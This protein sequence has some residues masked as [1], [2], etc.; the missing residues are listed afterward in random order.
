MKDNSLEV[1]R[2]NQ[3]NF[4]NNVILCNLLDRE[5]FTEIYKESNILKKFQNK[6]KKTF[7]LFDFLAKDLFFILYKILITVKEEDEISPEIKTHR[8]LIQKIL[9]AQNIK[10][11]RRRTKGNLVHSFNTLY[12]YLQWLFEFLE[13]EEIKELL[14]KRKKV[15]EETKNTKD[16]IQAQEDKKKVMEEKLE[17]LNK[18]CDEKEDN[19]GEEEN[20]KAE[21]N[22]EEVQKDQQKGLSQEGEITQ[23]Q[24]KGDQEEETLS[25]KDLQ[26]EEYYEGD[27]KKEGQSIGG[28]GE[29]P[30]SETFNL[31]NV[32]GESTEKIEDLQME[33]EAISKKIEKYKEK[34]KELEKQD[35]ILLEE[36]ERSIEEEDME[37]VADKAIFIIE[38]LDEKM[39]SIGSR[40]DEMKSLSFDLILKLS[41]T[42]RNP[43]LE[44][45]LKKVG[46]KRT[47]AHRGQRKKKKKFQ[48]IETS[49]VSSDD[50]NSITEDEYLN[51]GLGI[52]Q[53]EMDFYLRYLNAQLSTWKGSKV[54]KKR[55]G[56]IILCYDG[57]ASMEGE[58]IEEAKAHILAFMDIARK[59]NRK[60]LTIQFSS[61]E[62]K[63]QIAELNPR[64]NNLEKV[65]GI[66]EGFIG[67]GTDFNKP[68]LK[69]IE[70]IV[71]GAY[72]DADIL[73]ITDGEGE[74]QKQ[75]KEEFLDCKKR[76]KFKVYTILISYTKKQYKD[77]Q[78]ISD[79]VYYVQG[80][81]W[82]EE[83][84]EKIFRII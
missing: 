16:D 38:D 41:E 66:I 23:E 36:Y 45:F 63:L 51:L 49:R 57:S 79:E 2:K 53:L 9:E 61:S 27:H 60:M 37:D 20:K 84:S 19:Q 12:Y 47:L 67:K 35:Q 7:P 39:K 44:K 50:L 32:E 75:I 17:A 78:S 22:K 13:K 72:R 54:E 3:Y 24:G 11:L 43:K 34:L 71:S 8:I 29:S 42:Y 82:N 46:K 1:Y 21:S 28:E 62:E 52:E 33:M 25:Q 6:G 14:E 48:G 81:Q 15:L 76:Y 55:K 70:Y 31:E 64:K 77:I 58:R 74:I 30:T 10:N 4:E 73:F 18:P 56:P 83:V 80:G 40:T 59:Q 68:L 69:S 65:V 5:F 26:A